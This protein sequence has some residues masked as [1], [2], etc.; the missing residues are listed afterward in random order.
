MLISLSFVVMV[1]NHT[2]LVLLPVGMQLH[3][4]IRKKFLYPYAAVTKQY[5]LALGVVWWHRVIEKVDITLAAH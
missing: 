5:N 2:I 4:K 3:K 1:T